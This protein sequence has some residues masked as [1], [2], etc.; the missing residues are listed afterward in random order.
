[1]KWQVR[2]IIEYIIQTETQECKTVEA[3]LESDLLNLVWTQICCDGLSKQ[4]S[5]F[6]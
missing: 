5:D 2:H 6:I 4:P 1:M 3:L